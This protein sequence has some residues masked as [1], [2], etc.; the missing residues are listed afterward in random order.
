[1]TNEILITEDRAAMSHY[2]KNIY[3]GFVSCIPD[4]LVSRS[5]YRRYFVPQVP[6]DNCGNALMAPLPLRAVE[7]A[8]INGGFS[9][10][11][12]S[13]VRSDFLESRINEDTKIVA[14]S[15]HDPLGLGPATTTWSTIFG[16]IPH[17]RWEF[18]E[19]LSTLIRLRQKYDFKVILGGTGSWQLIQDNLYEKCKIDYVFV[20]ESENVIPELFKSIIDGSYD[21]ESIIRGQV[22]RPEKIPPILAPTNWGL[23]EI[24]R[25]CG[26]GCM[27]CSPTVSGKLRSLPI[28]TILRSV[29]VNLQAPWN[30]SKSILLHSE[31][32]FRYES[33]DREYRVNADAI[34]GLY[35]SLF[36]LGA[37]QIYI[38]HASFANF[39]KDED[40]IVEFTKYLRSHGMTSY[41]CQPGLETGSTR[42]MKAMMAGKMKPY[43]SEQWPWI[44]HEASRIMDQ[45]NWY[46]VATLIMGLPG[47]SHEDI[48]ATYHLVEDL[49]SYKALYI[50]LFFVPMTKTRLEG[51]QQFISENMSME[52]WRLMELCWKHNLEHIYD[53]YRVVD[54]ESPHALKIFLKTAVSALKA[55]FSIKRSGTLS[56]SP[57]APRLEDLGHT[58]PLEMTSLDEARFAV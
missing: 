27:Y 2:H 22:V 26:R 15:S 4:R 43:T 7:S 55:L 39:V 25:G 53:L 42:M 37:R 29:A 33:A 28:D 47:E 24:S 50:P 41:G 23:V 11:Q 34:F 5:L 49:Q 45:N 58:S 16:G 8:L 20:G 18:L 17:N 6:V 54:T 57:R 35:D 1:M 19:L 9:R 46:P 30:R 10:T 3:L 38:T 12:I 14:L 13:V 21:G 56:N 51:R 44:V 36:E 52:H 32:F 40:F 48:A 31:D